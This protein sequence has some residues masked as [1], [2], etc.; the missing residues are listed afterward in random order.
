MTIDESNL[1][2]K[3]IRIT[4][5]KKYFVQKITNDVS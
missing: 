3:V 1:K 4:R 2:R 5:G